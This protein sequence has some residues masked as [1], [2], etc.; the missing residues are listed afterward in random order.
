MVPGSSGL[1]DKKTCV[2]AAESLRCS[3]I[4]MDAADSVIAPLQR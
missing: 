4:D 1:I 3:Y 2:E